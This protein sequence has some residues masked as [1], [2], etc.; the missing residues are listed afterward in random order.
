MESMGGWING[1]VDGI[2]GWIDGWMGIDFGW[3]LAHANNG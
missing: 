1:W 2:I 3:I